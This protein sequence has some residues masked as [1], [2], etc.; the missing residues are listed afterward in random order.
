M[1][2]A[3]IVNAGSSIAGL[4]VAHYIN[5]FPGPI[6]VMILAILFLI[7]ILFDGVRSRIKRKNV[8]ITPHAC[9]IELESFGTFKKY[10]NMENNRME[11]EYDSNGD[12]G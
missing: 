9:K 7:S 11:R 3:G 6:I 1:I 12:E 4:F 5:L 2:M 10:L 8:N